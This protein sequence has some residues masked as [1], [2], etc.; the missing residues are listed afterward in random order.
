M[1][2]VDGDYRTEYANTLPFDEYEG[3][4]FGLLCT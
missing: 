2:Y 3:I 4:R 1:V